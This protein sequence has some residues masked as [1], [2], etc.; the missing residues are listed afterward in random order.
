MF[1]CSAG[2]SSAMNE[3][4]VCTHLLY[5]PAS[6]STGQSDP[7]ISRFGPNTESTTSK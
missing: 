3:R 4:N 5:P 2:V 6:V 7:N 1:S